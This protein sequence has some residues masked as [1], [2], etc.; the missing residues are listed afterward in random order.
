MATNVLIVLADQFR[1]DCLG[2]AGH[3]DLRTPSL[4]ALARDGIHYPNSFCVAPLCTPSRYT[5]L[6]G[7]LPAQHGVHGNNQP[8]G[9]G[10][11]TL[12]E[13]A[14]SAGLR[15]AAVGKMHFTPT[16]MDAGFDIMR[17][18]EQN[19]DGRLID[20]YHGE[21]IAAGLIDGVDL[22]DQRADY[23]RR[24]NA[25]YRNAFG[26]ATSDLPEEWHSTTW[27]ANQAIG[28]ID[29]SWTDGGQL[30]YLSFVKPH[31]PFDPPSPWDQQYDPS[32]LT[33]LPGYTD[34]V[35]PHDVEAGYFDN[36]A[37]SPSALRTVMAAYYGTISHLDFQL[38]RVIQ[39]LRDLDAYQNTMIIFT[40]DHG[41]YLGFH[42]MLLKAG[43][44]YDP[45]VQVPLIV[46]PA[47]AQH[48]GAAS[49]GPRVDQRLTSGQ[50]IVPTTLTGLGIRPAPDLDG[51]DLLDQDWRRDIVQTQSQ[52]GHM[53]RSASAKLITTEA[54]SMIFD[55]TADPLELAPQT[56]D[57]HEHA[58]LEL[59]LN[60]FRAVDAV[61]AG[62]ARDVDPSHRRD[63]AG[64][65]R[66]RAAQFENLLESQ[67]HP[68]L[69]R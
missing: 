59:A 29:D 13:R 32:R 55:L 27:T 63:D 26:T 64:T 42:H 16:Y 33:I 7:Y 8:L 4:D 12:P 46:K 69:S 62:Q 30:M 9:R 11:T 2:V 68:W 1:A 5:L 19:G 22:I 39:R 47:Q 24:A 17:L 3:P 20:D 49:D 51:H 43:P 54:G 44:M 25:D 34:T 35:P 37:L 41:E 23:R 57:A 53:A 40:S 66:R 61:P 67:G 21:L 48:D 56:V 60:E 10:L 52:H 31:H 58:D 28:L 36:R 45:V 38:G 6:T 14:R 18:C 15:T 65:A 50:D